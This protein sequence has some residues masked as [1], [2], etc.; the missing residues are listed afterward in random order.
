MTF[1]YF[2][3]DW[4][5]G[6]SFA[7]AMEDFIDGLRYFGYSQDYISLQF[8]VVCGVKVEISKINKKNI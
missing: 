4:G 3:G 1:F 7:K 6:S 5:V 8:W 2:D